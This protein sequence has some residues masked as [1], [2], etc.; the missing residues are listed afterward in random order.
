MENN[1]YIVLKNLVDD[2]VFTMNDNMMS[3]DKV[4]YE[5]Y[6]IIIKNI[7]NKLNYK[8]NWDCLATKYRVSSGKKKSTSNSTDASGFH[9][10]INVVKGNNVP[11][12]YTLVIYLDNSSLEIIPNSH[13]IFDM[14]NL[15]EKKTI[16]FNIGDA[17]LFKS[18][19]LHRG[20]F[21]NQ[22]KNKSRKC[23]QIFEIY[24][25]IEDFN[26]LSKY[27]LTIPGTYKSKISNISLY[28]VQRYFNIPF[29]VNFVNEKTIDMNIDK[30]DDKYYN[31][32][33]YISPEGTR[34]RTYNNIDNGNM[35]RL[36]NNVTDTKHNNRDHYY[37]IEEYHIRIVLKYFIILILFFMIIY[38]IF[39]III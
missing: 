32:F 19:L 31:Y 35:Y 39:S 25:N 33:K 22:Q 18:T 8:F 34:K 9:R 12:I 5:K 21:E 17:I 7:L 15:E 29:I 24:K 14:N 38:Y 11:D 20:K 36:I 27:V 6:D 10:D 13:N 3:N 26:R 28:F 30:K 2:M 37:F 1:G 23:I 4:N 16:N